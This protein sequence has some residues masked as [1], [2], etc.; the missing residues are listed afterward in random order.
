MLSKANPQ[1]IIETTLYPQKVTVWSVP[2]AEGFIG[3]YLKIKTAIML[4]PM[5]NTIEPSLMTIS[6]L[7]STVL[8]WKILGY[9]KTVERLNL[10]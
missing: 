9:N 7:N 1:T 8:M 3:P 2:I 6:C 10:P 5:R 4:K